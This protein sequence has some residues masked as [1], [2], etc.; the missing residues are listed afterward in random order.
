MTPHLIT[1]VLV[2]CPALAV[3]GTSYWS[4]KRITSFDDTRPMEGP[5]A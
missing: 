1:A 4:G 5:T 3:I 2:V